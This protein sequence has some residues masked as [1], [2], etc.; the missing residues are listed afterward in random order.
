MKNATNEELMGSAKSIVQKIKVI[1]KHCKENKLD[2]KTF[3][4]K[5]EY[6]AYQASLTYIKKYLPE[7][8]VDAFSLKQESENETDPIKDIE[9]TPFVTALI[10]WKELIKGIFSDLSK[11]YTGVQI[12]ISDFNASLVPISLPIVDDL[13]NDWI[14]FDTVKDS[15]TINNA[16]A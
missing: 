13:L 1:Q 8:K 6:K 12:S 4:S 10:K 11:E 7:I 2:L 15:T 9:K 14:N 5:K 16:G 3:L